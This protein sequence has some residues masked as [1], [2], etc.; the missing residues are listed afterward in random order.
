MSLYD[1]LP[2]FKASYNLLLN[3]FQF[4]ANFSREYKYT[5]AGKVLCQCN[6]NRREIPCHSAALHSEG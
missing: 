2:V 3:I 5:V 1:E 6:A 4:T